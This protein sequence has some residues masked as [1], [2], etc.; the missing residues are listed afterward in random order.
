MRLESQYDPGGG[1]TKA[2]PS[3]GNSAMTAVPSDMSG[4]RSPVEC[5]PLGSVFPLFCNVA[6]RLVFRASPIETS[7]GCSPVN[8]TLCFYSVFQSLYTGLYDMT[9]ITVYVGSYYGEQQTLKHAYA[10][11]EQFAPWHR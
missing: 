4:P 3:F 5:G 6:I 8:C 1:T 7:K 11:Q 10:A 2:C 9:R